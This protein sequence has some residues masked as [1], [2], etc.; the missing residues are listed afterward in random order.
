[1]QISRDNIA[2]KYDNNMNKI[3]FLILIIV[4]VPSL[5]YAQGQTD[6]TSLV[7]SS[8]QDTESERRKTAIRIFKKG[9]VF[10]PAYKDY[11]KNTADYQQGFNEGMSFL[12]SPHSPPQ[13]TDIILKSKLTEVSTKSREYACG[14]FA[15]LE[16]YYAISSYIHSE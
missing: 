9:E 12:T 5:T 6:Q 11:I 4:A 16:G 15:A 13:A 1:M 3:S 7:T 10:I 2:I 8:I 14:F